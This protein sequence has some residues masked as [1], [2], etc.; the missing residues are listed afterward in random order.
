M[1]IPTWLL[2]VGIIWPVIAAFAWFITAI[3]RRELQNWREDIIEQVQKSTEQI[4]P[5]ANGGLS[6]TDLHKKVDATQ[7]LLIDHLAT[8]DRLDHYGS[9]D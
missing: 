3:L 8:H 5:N 4:Q 7:R 2:D 1:E 6:L 9:P